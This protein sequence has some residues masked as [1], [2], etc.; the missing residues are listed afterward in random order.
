MRGKAKPVSLARKLVIDLMHVSVPLVAVKRTMKIERLVK[1]RAE[2]DVRPGWT[3]I[4]A[5]AYC[6]VARDEPWLRTFYLKWPWPHFYEVPRSVVGAAVVRDSFDK[7]VPILLKIGSA[8]EFSLTEVEA[9]LQR[10]KNAPLDEVPAF[11]RLLRITRWPLPIRRLVWAAG[12]NIGRQR[13]N[14]FGT[15]AITSLATLGSETT[16]ANSPGPSLITYGLVRADHTMELLF[17]W[18]HRI[19]DGVLAARVLQRL[20]D[21][22]NNEIADELL[23]GGASKLRSA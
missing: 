17:H 9:I 11:K 22:M 12:L 21:V 23:A 10:G 16:I 15:I 13:A 8:D 19:F 4:I 5:K 7:D 3:T 20:E 18:D 1:A 14:Y 2:Q 6:I